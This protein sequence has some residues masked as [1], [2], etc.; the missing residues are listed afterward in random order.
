[1]T[2][3]ERQVEPPL[4]IRQ[5]LADL[6]T[7]DEDQIR[8]CAGGFGRASGTAAVHAGG[9][10]HLRAVRENRRRLGEGR[11]RGRGQGPQ[12][13]RAAGAV[14]VRSRRRSN[15]SA[16]SVWPPR[17]LTGPQRSARWP[18]G[19]RGP[20]CGTRLGPG[21]HSD[22]LHQD[23]LDATGT[24]WQEGRLTRFPIEPLFSLA[25][26]DPIMRLARTMHVDAAQLHR[27]RREGLSWVHADRWA[28]AL[29][30]HPAE[31]W[32]QAW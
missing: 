2:V 20:V 32:G 25:H 11:C 24:V 16:R 26:G 23:Q 8:L 9:G 1:M 14:A 12:R 3:L 30:F 7:S 15:G 19:P 10:S 13:R 6:D 5:A 28:V 18:R 22:R 21:Q 31:V 29:G 17:R 4:E 27:A